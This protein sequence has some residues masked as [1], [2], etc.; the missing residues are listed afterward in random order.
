[1]DPRTT[2]PRLQRFLLSRPVLVTVATLVGLPLLLLGGAALHFWSTAA[3]FD[4]HSPSAPS[5]LY[6]APFE[7]RAGAGMT[8]RTLDDA[9]DALGYRPGMPPL[10][11][12]EYLRD[13]GRFEIG[14]RAGEV[15]ADGL[16]PLG[17]ASLEVAL[18]EGRVAGM[19]VG[20]V[21]LEQGRAVRLGRPLLYS[22]YD[23]GRRE[24]RPVRLDEL[25]E[26]V[27][28]AVLAAED[29]RFFR[30]S[31]V[32]PVG[33][34]RA[35]WQNA[36]A[37]EIRQGGS[38][39]TQQLVKNLYLSPRRTVARKAREAVL[40]LLLEAR[41]G[42]ERILEA[43]LNEIYWGHV[44]GVN[45]H[46][47]GAAAHAYFG[48]RPAE[49]DLGEAAVLAGMIRA[50]AAHSPI[51]APDA[52]RARRDWV[53]RRMAA[54]RWI[55]A[56]QLASETARPIEP[57]AAARPAQRAPY[58]AAAAAAEARR[59]FGV[60]QLGGAGLR[61][62]S[63][64]SLLDQRAAEREVATGLARLERTW[65]RGRGDLE[66]A[67]VSLD[68]RTGA[69]L[70]WV[71][72]R[73]WRRSQ[74]DRVA[75]ARRQAG[76]LFKPIVYA[77]AL[78]H[79]R[80]SPWQT[81]RDTPILVRYDRTEWRP[82]NSDGGFRGE[83]TAR[84]ALEQS[85]NVPVVRVAMETG[86]PVVQATARD[87]GITAPLPDVPS[88]ALGTCAVTPL[89]LAVAYG[90]LAT[91]G[92]RPSPFTLESI[93][94]PAGEPIPG[95]PV[96]EPERALPSETAYVVT[97]M[98][99]GVLT[100]GTA[101]SAGRLGVRGPLAGKTG[102]T[103]DRRDSWFAGYSADRVTVVWVGYDDNSRS[104]LSGTRGALPL[105]SRFTV[106]VAPTGGYQAIEA[107]QGFVTADI[108]PSTGML[109]G[110]WCPR[111]VREEL[112]GWRAPL[113]ECTL[114]QPQL[115]YH[116]GLDVLDTGRVDSQPTLQDLLTRGVPETPP[117]RLRADVRGLF[118]EGQ[119]IRVDGA[120][121]AL[122]VVA[123]PGAEPVPVAPRD[124]VPAVPPDAPAPLAA[125]AAGGLRR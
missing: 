16:P 108:D 118:G 95:E 84:E 37:G 31:G 41:F 69:V 107:P 78:Q 45:L 114:H 76:S 19:R 1:M 34:A 24:C 55:E 74:F 77:A 88:L 92:L 17:G 50:P 33:I 63:T 121:P 111:R 110:P 89:E 124:A 49:L 82:R 43:Y 65:E 36:R 100:R 5:R 104:R 119:T 120:P 39:L 122:E 112:P 90:T 7:L 105:W 109:A 21:E 64:L 20:A 117:V 46:G 25:P 32:A 125:A 83:V 72:G 87:M 62:E 73:D 40:A 81:L 113:H 59:R 99:R 11:A 61:L 123:R 29:A 52:A 14:V 102:T 35:A 48:K 2:T 79:G 116:P 98:L 60:E 68:P 15:E 71:G 8:A 57:R 30:H 4:D 66:G 106:R 97:S 91:S 96:A 58:F 47:I 9:L 54:R 6:A 3:S 85:L 44:D 94:D 53:L 80:L 27:V 86:I 70:A 51:A 22:F 18:R 115:A 10:R 101:W 23:E 28:R 75:Q 93:V 103:D 42:K 67:L 13:G 12:G 38:T 26:H 56:D